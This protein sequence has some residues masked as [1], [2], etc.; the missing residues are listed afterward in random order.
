MA[1]AVQQQEKDFPG[2]FAIYVFDPYRGFEFGF[3][4]NR[5]MYLA[6]AVKI[7]FMVE[8]FRQEAKGK[9]SLDETLE[10]GPEDVRDGAP[11][12]NHEPF[13]SKVRIG[14][15]LLHM[16]Q[17]S[18]NAASD[19]LAKRVGL[20]RIA[21]GLK[22]DGLGAL[23]PF[24]F[25]LDVRRGIYRELD[26]SADDLSPEQIRAIRWTSIWQP[27]VDKLTA[28]LQRPPGTFRPADLMAAYGR[29]YK[30][31]ANTGTMKAVGDLLA[32]MRA[33]QLVSAKASEAMLELMYGAQTSRNRLLG[34]LPADVRVAHKTG[35]QY[36]RVCDLGVIE[37]PDDKPL[38]V[39]GCA[40]DGPVRESEDLLAVLTRTAFD[41]VTEDHKSMMAY[42][43][44]GRGP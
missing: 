25:L 29:F 22:A 30:S 37:L 7:A 19:M 36:L 12:L 8:V 44:P 10:Y 32:R 13:G 17:A 26:L 11:R 35:S 31:Q 39:C 42:A 2:S 3:N 20:Q 27:Q 38:V 43:G 21:Q 33:G 4:E 9:L 1:R 5:R 40:E 18:D 34:R 28:T 16:M 24:S 14:D 15:L 41:L 23:G 6:S